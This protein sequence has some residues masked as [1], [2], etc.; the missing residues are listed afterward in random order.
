MAMLHLLC[1]RIA[2]GKSTL[3]DALSAVPGT[4][5]LNEDDRTATLY[6][7]EIATAEDFRVRTARIEA[8]LGPHV[9]A[10]LRAGLDVV[11]D[12]HANTVARRAWMKGIVERSSASHR[13]HWLDVPEGTCL[14]RLHARNARGEHRYV[15]DDATAATFTRFFVP[16]G[17]DE[18][19]DVVVHRPD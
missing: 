13:L 5:R 10:L 9:E 14:E 17:P 16:P 15:V 2:A 8:L 3:A 4:I 6:P 18:G 1:G 7:G 19:F 11:L 12:L